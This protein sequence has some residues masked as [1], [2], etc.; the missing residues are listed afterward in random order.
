MTV[1]DVSRARAL[2]GLA[3]WEEACVQFLAADAEHPLDVEDVELLAEAA[4]LTGRHEVAV[5]ALERAFGLRASTGDLSPAAAAAFW[6]YTE[7]HYAG[8]FASAGG[9]ISRLRDLTERLAAEQEPGWLRIAEARQCI[10]QERYDDARAALTP[11]LAQGREAGDV[12][13]ET[14]ARLLT[15]RSLLL[16]GHPAEGL[17]QLDD[18]MLRVTSG[19]TSPRMT[20]MLYCAAIGTCEAEAWELS[21]ALEWARALER[22]MTSLPTLFG[23]AF[24]DN[25][26]V[27]RA[28]LKRHRGELTEARTELED[29]ARSLAD[30]AGVQVAGHAWYELGEVHRMLGEDD[31]AELAYR[32]AVSL[33]AGVHPGLA[34]LRLRQ[35]DS[36]TALSGLRRSLAE[37][38]RTQTRGHLL[39]AL[40]TV[41]VAAGETDEARSALAELGELARAMGSSALDAELARSSG[42][43]A[44]ADG[45]PEAALASL[46]R[47]AD[48]WRQFGAAYE[49]AR[50]CVLIARACH[51]LGDEEG[52]R[53]ELESARECFERLG[54]R[55]ELEAVDALDAL[56]GPDS[57]DAPAVLR[58]RGAPPSEHGLSDRELQVLRLVA[59][60]RTNRSIATELFLSERTV[61]RHLSS[62]FDKLGVRSRTEAATFA[63]ENHLL[64][65]T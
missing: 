30:G 26:R 38:T 14:V 22:W 41:A 9:W 49:T 54:A 29:A 25:C 20:S 31:D 17:A 59:S 37:A 2:H 18:A 43:M 50:T 61:H 10:G 63:V 19:Q 12:D 39:P 45:R 35:G 5:S 56:A 48:A 40:V 3:R 34:L 52:A 23:G 65:A 51:A 64:H 16:A 36:T 53:L 13:L 57:L 42:E 7:F 32:R 24:L 44:M 58:S 47:S 33:G 62:I 8:E 4:Q 11:A 46:R 28:S 15:A 6:L 1:A 27:Y 55:R 60:G 21:R